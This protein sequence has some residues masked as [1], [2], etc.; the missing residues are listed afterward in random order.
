MTDGAKS[1]SKPLIE[2]A[3]AAARDVAF[4]IA[5]FMVFAGLAYRDYF[6]VNQFELPSYMMDASPNIVLFDAYLVLK[7]NVFRVT[8]AIFVAFFVL[9]GTWFVA[10]KVWGATNVTLARSLVVLAAV[11][12]MVLAF[13]GLDWIASHTAEQRAQEIRNEKY[14]GVTVHIRPGYPDLPTAALGDNSRITIIEQTDKTVF[15]HYLQ[16]PNPQQ[17]NAPA[18]NHVY[19]VPQDAINYIE[20][21]PP[22]ENR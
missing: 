10:N 2:T 13:P 6:Y 22:G 3:L 9:T 11:V 18:D 5:I 16:P 15:V 8:V 14:V 4:V 21:I 17:P 1:D 12:L 20:S 7:Y 19:A